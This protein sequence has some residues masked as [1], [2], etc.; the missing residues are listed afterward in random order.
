MYKRKGTVRKKAPGSLCVDVSM[1]L[2]SNLQEE[3]RESP[4]G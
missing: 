2:I 3:N 4:S 1:L